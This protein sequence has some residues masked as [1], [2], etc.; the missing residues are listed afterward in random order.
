MCLSVYPFSLPWSSQGFSYQIDESLKKLD[1]L[2]DLDEVDT[3]VR[4]FGE[5][6]KFTTLRKVSHQA[7]RESWEL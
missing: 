1:F 5:K 4:V 3:V 6:K 7:L 2:R